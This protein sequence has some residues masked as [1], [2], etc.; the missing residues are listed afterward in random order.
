M[1]VPEDFSIVNR[2]SVPVKNFKKDLKKIDVRFGTIVSVDNV[3]GSKKLAALAVNFGDYERTIIAGMKKELLLS[4]LSL[5]S[6][7]Q[8]EPGPDKNPEIS[9]VLTL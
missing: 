1:F 4:W 6:Q 8:T 2:K 7:F 5:K 3:P 9:S